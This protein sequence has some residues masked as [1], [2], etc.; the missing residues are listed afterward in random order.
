M[1]ATAK[2]ESI[3]A[4][5]DFSVSSGNAVEQAALLA[6]RWGASLCLLHVFNDGAWSTL[7]SLYQAEHWA[8]REP[9]LA[10]RDRLSQL[11]DELGARHGIA[12]RA[13]T[14]TGRAAA[15]TAAFA[16][17][18]G[19]QLLVVGEHGEDWLGDTMIGGTALK[20]LEQAGLPVLLAR[21][22]AGVHY[23]NLLVGVD[24]SDNALRAAQAASALFPEAR[25]TLSHAYLVSFEGRMRLAGA[26]DADIEGYRRNERI[27]AEQKM[28]DF[29]ARLGGAARRPTSLIARGFPPAVL[30]E[31]AAELAVD[32]IVV[33]RHGG[34]RIAERLLGSVTQNVLYQADSDVLLVP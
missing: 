23:A 32:L 2:I 34:G 7:R 6:K 25:L 24:F 33:G 15:E 17:A 10:A 26:N 8:G 16:A 9:V 27:L 29:V 20:L 11:A 22:P 19:A 30:F 3:V 13:E 31:Q 4:A 14:R 21:R 18:C 1:T 12:V 28:P 5:T